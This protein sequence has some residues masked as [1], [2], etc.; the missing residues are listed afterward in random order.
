MTYSALCRLAAAAVDRQ[1]CETAGRR[2]EALR[3]APVQPVEV[4]PAHPWRAPYRT[5]RPVAAVVAQLQM[6]SRQQVGEGVAVEVMLVAVHKPL[7][8]L[9]MAVVALA[10]A[11]LVAPG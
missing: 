5:E 8:L 2:T 1:L 10:G 9:K 4:V 11:L 3:T 7:T 6:R